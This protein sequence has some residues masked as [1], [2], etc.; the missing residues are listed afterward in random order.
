MPEKAGLLKL[1]VNSALFAPELTKMAHINNA[2]FI[3][4]APGNRY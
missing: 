2:Y 3:L 4:F 1:C